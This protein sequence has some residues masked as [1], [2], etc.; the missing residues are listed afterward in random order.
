MHDVAVLADFRQPGGASAAVAAEVHAQAEAA[1]STVLIHAPDARAA[2]GFGFRPRI[3]DLIRDGA[4][5]L[6]RDDQPVAA[7]L[8]VV[9]R[10]WTRPAAL[11]V[12]AER[13]VLV[14]GKPPVEP[15]VYEQAR[16]WFGAEA[17]WAPTGPQAREQLLRVAPGVRVTT[18]DWHEII[19]VAH[20][21]RDRDG[22]V[23]GE[24]VVGLRGPFP[25][26]LGDLRVRWFGDSS[27]FPHWELVPYG[28]ELPGEFL[29]TLDFLI[30]FQ[31]TFS[32]S[33]LESMAAGVPV[34][35]GEHLR[36]FLG[37]AALYSSPGRVA[38]LVRE[39]YADPDR[40]RG[41]VGRAREFA[42]RH[43]GHR[44]HLAR[45]ARYGIRPRL[46]VPGPRRDPRPVV[47]APPRRLLMLGDDG[48]KVCTAIARRL[49]SDMAAIIA[50]SSHPASFHAASPHPGS[51]YAASPRP[52]P[53]A[54]S[55]LAQAE[56]FLTERLPSREALGAS[57]ARW[58]RLLRDRLTH[59]AELHAPEVVV[60]DG[61]PHE[62]IVQAARE[63][64]DIVWVWMR[65]ALRPR[66]PGAGWDGVH[67][68]EPGEFAALAVP[69]EDRAHRVDPVLFLDPGELLE[70]AAAREELGLGDGPLA[71]LAPGTVAGIAEHLGR[72]GFRVVRDEP[73]SRCLRAFDLTVTGAGYDAFHERLAYGIPTVFVP[74]REED[75]G[76]ARFADAAG[77]ALT[78]EDPESDELEQV[79][80][81]VVRPE[82]RAALRGR[83]TELAFS[84]GAAAA[85]TWLSGLRARV[86]G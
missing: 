63:R 30:D 17:A 81:A 61:V 9:R 36:P 35:V 53:Q 45:L 40:Y 39:V 10:P 50:T 78:V 11:S 23:A 44:S 12:R 38:S 37:G 56:G 58:N 69:D 84:N 76:R 3:S 71:L 82:V 6:A 4:A 24:P 57:E 7:R 85:A 70:P 65:R 67:V 33:A 18:T 8:L 28:A 19:D 68:L 20:W 51:F 1:L 22:F 14:V 42:E 5:T 66:H 64:T 21:W 27:P 60:V 73:P 41:V 25:I 52:S 26:D 55:A 32:R 29:R 2:E 59:L 15:T 74:G 80:D 83:C 16:R 72:H 13:T 79:L 75:R 31:Q 43:Y 54:A 48:A 62:G 49:P 47:I 77:V 86:R 34:I 46:N